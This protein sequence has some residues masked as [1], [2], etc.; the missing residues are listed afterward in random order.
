M[1]E[2]NKHIE[3][4]RGFTATLNQAQ[5]DEWEVVANEWERDFAFPKEALNPFEV[6]GEGTPDAVACALM[7][8]LTTHSDQRSSDLEGVG[9]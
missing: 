7:A 6:V 1:V 8:S 4:H 9:R 2:R 3:A 5:V